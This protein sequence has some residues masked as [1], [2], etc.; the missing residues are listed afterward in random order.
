MVLICIFSVLG[1]SNSVIILFLDCSTI[2]EET[3]DEPMVGVS[4][5]IEGCCFC[6]RNE[7]T[8]GIASFRKCLESRTGMSYNAPDAHISAFACYEVGMHLVK[9]PEVRIH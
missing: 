9:N 8:K 3:I 5:L 6:V 7:F 1:N 4:K 2:L